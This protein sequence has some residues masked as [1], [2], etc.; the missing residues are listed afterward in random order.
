MEQVHLFVRAAEAIQW[1]SAV[2]VPLMVRSILARKSDFPIWGQLSHQK[3]L[4]SKL[5]FQ[6]ATSEESRQPQVRNSVW[7][8][9]LSRV[10][11]VRYTANWPLG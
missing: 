8:P 6:V 5:E 11:A 1:S 7:L 10:K 2:Q 3:P 4:L 9:P